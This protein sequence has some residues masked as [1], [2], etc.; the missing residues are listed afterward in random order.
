[1]HCRSFQ[2]LHM[3]YP[4]RPWPACLVIVSH[5][6]PYCVFHCGHIGRGGLVERNGKMQ[7]TSLT[8]S[9]SA[10][11]ASPVALRGGGPGGSASHT[12]TNMHFPLGVC[13]H[14]PSPTWPRGP[15]CGCRPFHS[16]ASRMAIAPCAVRIPRK[17]K[18]HH[19]G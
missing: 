1:M 13:F 6:F 14:M 18:P 17:A 9:R 2:L 12:H 4:K 8:R 5:G 15:H 16:K 19:A 11:L 7:A 3:A 10:A